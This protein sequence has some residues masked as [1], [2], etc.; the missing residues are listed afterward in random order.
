[1][2]NLKCFLEHPPIPFFRLTQKGIMTTYLPDLVELDISLLLA[3]QYN[4][5]LLGL[6]YLL[7]LGLLSGGTPKRVFREKK[8]FGC[9]NC[10]SIIACF[11]DVIL[12]D[13]LYSD[14]IQL[15][16]YMCLKKHTYNCVTVSLAYSKKGL[17]SEFCKVQPCFHRFCKY[18]FHFVLYPIL[19]YF[20]QIGV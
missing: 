2:K 12:N 4:Y 1:M 17:Q 3:I 8:V 20:F 13:T 15:S 16:W 6:Q 10:F 11:L 19:F 9:L 5:F 18:C 7:I 14:G